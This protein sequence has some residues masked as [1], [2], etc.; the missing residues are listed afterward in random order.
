MGCVG[1]S[2]L[3]LGRQFETSWLLPEML[4]DAF[5]GAGLSS[6]YTHCAELGVG[7]GKHYSTRGGRARPQSVELTASVSM[8]ARV[9]CPE[10]SEIPCSDECM[11]RVSILERQYHQA[12]LGLRAGS[13]S[14]PVCEAAS[15]LEIW[16]EG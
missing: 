5:A 2:R 14:Y 9:R 15:A 4:A 10:G 11:L 7:P 8:P 16:S 6:K 13:V 12:S 1:R 3:R